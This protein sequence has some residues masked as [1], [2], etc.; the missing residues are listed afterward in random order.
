LNPEYIK[1]SNTLP[2]QQSCEHVADDPKKI[3]AALLHS[4]LKPKANISTAPKTTINHIKIQPHQDSAT[5]SQ[6]QLFN[7]LIN[8]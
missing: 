3:M 7:H 8:N 2:Y 5:P 6:Q 1:V 4:Y